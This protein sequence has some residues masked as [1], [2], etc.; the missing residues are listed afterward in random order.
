[1]QIVGINTLTLLDFPKHTACIIFTAGCNFRCGFCYNE[2]FVLPEKLKDYTENMIPEEVFFNFLNTRK[3]LLDGVVISGGEPTLQTD[4][5]NFIQQVR[6]EGFLVK[7]DTNGTNPQILTE[8]L[9]KNLVEYIAMDLKADFK[10][11]KKITGT[12]IDVEKIQK[13]MELIMQSDIDYEFRTTL[14]KG[15]HTDEILQNMAKLLQGAKK[16]SLQNFENKHVL[17]Q[18]F[19]QYFPFQTQEL[20][21]IAEIFKPFVKEVLVY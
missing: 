1:M 16:Y 21:E 3:G 5:V 18:K 7:L 10:N 20:K 11:Y 12:E 8:I 4:L 15:I 6:Q 14:I 13:S 2:E 19:L 9:A 17:D